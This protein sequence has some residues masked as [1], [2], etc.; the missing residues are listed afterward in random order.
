MVE[1]KRCGS[2]RIVKS[3]MVRKKQRYLCKQ[4]GYHFVEGDERETVPSAVVKALCMIFHALGVDQQYSFIAKYL[5][6]NASLI[7]RW[8][9]KPPG[10]YKPKW[11]NGINEFM[12]TDELIRW[13]R[14][15]NVAKSRSVLMIDNVVNGHYIAVIIQPI[16]KR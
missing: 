2:T 12:S 10:E 7:H 5:N 15:R 13:I 11:D 4:C 8:I 16:K 3:G 9:N 1:C 6:R 14:H